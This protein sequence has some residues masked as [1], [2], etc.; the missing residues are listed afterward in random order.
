VLEHVCPNRIGLYPLYSTW[1]NSKRLPEQQRERENQ[2]VRRLQRPRDSVSEGIEVLQRPDGEIKATGHR[3]QF[4][5][6]RRRGDEPRTVTG[7]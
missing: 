5:L 7:T 2:G 3:E 6:E 4:R 1:S